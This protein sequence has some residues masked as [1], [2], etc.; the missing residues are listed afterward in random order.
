MMSSLP[1]SSRQL[2]IAAIAEYKYILNKMSEES[3]RFMI[4]EYYHRTLAP[5]VP[6]PI[7]IMGVL[8][9]TYG[10]QDVRLF[11]LEHTQETFQDIQSYFE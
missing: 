11:Y 10:Y 8:A 4:E 5:D 9:F 3:M 1:L 6:K 2:Q 7:L